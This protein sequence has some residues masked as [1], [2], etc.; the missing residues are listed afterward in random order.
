MH[1]VPRLKATSGGL[2][3]PTDFFG[4]GDTGR[5]DARSPQPGRRYVRAAACAF[6]G[7]GR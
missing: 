4:S 1:I 7:G 6:E 3:F 5:A 2:E